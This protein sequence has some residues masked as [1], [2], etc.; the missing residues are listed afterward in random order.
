MAR[1]GGQLVLAGGLGEDLRS[2]AV[3][4][5][6]RVHVVLARAQTRLIDT[7]K[8]SLASTNSRPSGPSRCTIRLIIQTTASAALRD[9]PPT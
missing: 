8:A 7:T 1:Q 9:L 3:V 5:L 6:K 2:F 4:A